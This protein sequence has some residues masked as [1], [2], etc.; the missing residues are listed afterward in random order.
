MRAR[1]NN[2]Y[3]VCQCYLHLGFI[4]SIISFFPSIRK[5]ILEIFSMSNTVI[6]L[7]LRFISPLK[8]VVGTLPSYTTS[9]SYQR[10]TWVIISWNGVFLK[11]NLPDFQATYFSTSTS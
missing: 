3:L 9:I 1:V 8:V 5:G 2:H 7:T 10:A 11:K 4:Y 6:R